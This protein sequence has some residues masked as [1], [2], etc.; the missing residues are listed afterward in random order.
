MTDKDKEFEE[1]INNHAK[2]LTIHKEE[3]PDK[4]G[5]NR[6]VVGYKNPPI[7]TRFKPGEIHNPNGRPKD[8]KYISEH[9]KAYLEDNPGI[10]HNIVL[11]WLVE[12]RTGNVQALKELLDRTEGKVAEKI[13][14]TENPVTIILRPARDRE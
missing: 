5:N 11:A 9:L 13:E 8:K 4:L 3:I 14:G 2:T 1:M 12:A 10:L 6:E 7:E